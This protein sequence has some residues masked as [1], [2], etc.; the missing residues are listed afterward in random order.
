[1]KAKTILS[2]ARRRLREALR[3]ES[4]EKNECGADLYCFELPQERALA[5]REGDTVLLLTGT[6]VNEKPV[7]C[8]ITTLWPTTG[9]PPLWQVQLYKVSEPV[10]L[11]TPHQFSNLVWSYRHKG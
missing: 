4:P 10:I 3:R 9:D 6:V 7:R 8:V 5:L 1:M 11:L 2:R